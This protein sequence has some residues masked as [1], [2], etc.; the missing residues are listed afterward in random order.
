[1]LRDAPRNL[2]ADAPWLGGGAR[3]SDG[4]NDGRI[5][6]GI[7]GGGGGAFLPI[8]GAWRHND[9][10]GLAASLCATVELILYKIRASAAGAHWV[11]LRPLE[12]TQHPSGG[13]A[14]M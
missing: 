6:G 9:G 10:R 5:R 7:A 4:K 14:T 11:R 3:P 1:M 8:G 12:A 2:C 13:P